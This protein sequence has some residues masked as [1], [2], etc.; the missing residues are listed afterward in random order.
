LLENI[1]ERTRELGAVGA[2]ERHLVSGIVAR[3]RLQGL[4]MP[5]CDR[6]E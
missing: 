3:Q 6:G 2:G 4:R 5:C 1:L